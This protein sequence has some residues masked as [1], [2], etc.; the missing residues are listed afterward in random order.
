MMMLYEYRAN[1]RALSADHRSREVFIQRA[2]QL[3]L[4]KSPQIEMQQY[5]SRACDAGRS[6]CGTGIRDQCDMHRGPSLHAAHP[7]RE[8]LLPVVV[9]MLLQVASAPLSSTRPHSLQNIGK[10]FN[11]A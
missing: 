7:A 5:A 3:I 2:V 8:F 9:C 10:N 4:I 6:P 1:V 11:G